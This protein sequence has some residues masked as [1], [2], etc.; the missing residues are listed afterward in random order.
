MFTICTHCH[1]RFRLSA[2]ALKAAGGQV[3]CGKCHEV[4]DAY[5]N[6]EGADLAPE[7]PPPAE[8]VPEEAVEMEDVA[9]SADI[10]LS[11]TGD[12]DATPELDAPIAAEPEP[13]TSAPELKARRRKAREDQLIDDLFASLPD[14]QEPMPEV[15][16]AM[17]A[18][19]T[20]MVEPVMQMGGNSGEPAPMSY[21]HV[22][23]LTVAGTPPSR[24]PRS[25]LWWVGSFVLLLVLIAQAVD[26]D[27][28]A[29]AQN[30]VIG[31]SLQA[32]YASLGRPLA[33]PQSV[34][35]W[36]VG[37]LNVTSDPDNSGALSIT[38]TLANQGATQPWPS[39]RVVL[40]DRF[41]EPLRARDFKPADY[42]P[43]GQSNAVLAPGLA[44]RF[45]LDVVDPGPDAVGFSLT[46]CLDG[47]DG[48]VCAP[49]SASD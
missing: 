6:L 46:P 10:A 41:G 38:G 44:A 1:T 15:A 35:D 11:V 17:S 3:R 4:F 22:E 12:E 31:T 2:A 19:E 45:R 49:P 13:I 28:A 16:P 30:P 27:R 7:M 36:N 43:A 20:G 34:S 9:A 33:A 40:T 21:A 14:A 24:R 37:A 23:E 47:P 8:A 39:L 5:E 29:L 32:L 18:A 42:L 48:R 26:M 25:A